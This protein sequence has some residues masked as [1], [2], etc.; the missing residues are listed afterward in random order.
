MYIF[1]FFS[2]SVHSRKNKIPP[3]QK[4]ENEDT[5]DIELEV[6]QPTDVTAHNALCKNYSI[7]DA[8]P[9]EPATRRR[10]MSMQLL[11]ERLSGYYNSL[12]FGNKRKKRNIDSL[13]DIYDHVELDADPYNSTIKQ[14]V[15]PQNEVLAEIYDHVTDH[16]G[17]KQSPKVKDEDEI[18]K[19]AKQTTE[20]VKPTALEMA[21]INFSDDEISDDGPDDFTTD[22][23]YYVVND[24][25]HAD[26]YE[27]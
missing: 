13:I 16:G 10:P 21:K 3:K 20:N 24:E 7:L 9:T 22:D 23:T 15:N 8:T 18:I 17:S 25:E 14:E 19:N 5:S 2:Y 6:E 12:V 26:Y 1:L 11:K 4:L 27:I